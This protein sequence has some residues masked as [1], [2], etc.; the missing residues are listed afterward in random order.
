VTRKSISKSRNLRTPT[1]GKFNDI[2]SDF[3]EIKCRC[4]KLKNMKI[5]KNSTK[6]SSFKN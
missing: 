6:E 5:N 2:G 3:L 1:D 4:S